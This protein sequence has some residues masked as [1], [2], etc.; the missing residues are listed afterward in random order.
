MFLLVSLC[1]TALV[2]G[3]VCLALTYV[4]SQLGNVLQAALSLFGMIAGPLLGLFTLGMVFP[5]ANKW[6]RLAFS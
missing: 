2:F 1:S 6:V 5:W 4:A 3:A